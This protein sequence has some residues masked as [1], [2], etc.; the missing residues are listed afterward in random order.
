M[1]SDR[2]TQM[3]VLSPWEIIREEIIEEQDEMFL[4]IFGYRRNEG[5]KMKV[6]KKKQ[7]KK[8]EVN[9]PKRRSSRIADNNVQPSTSSNSDDEPK[10]KTE[11]KLSSH[12]VKVETFKFTS[13]TEISVSSAE[14]FPCKQCDKT[15]NFNNS[16][17][18]HIIAMHHNTWYNCDICNSSFRYNSNLKRHTDKVHTSSTVRYHCNECVQS[19]TYKHNLKAHI[20]KFHAHTT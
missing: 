4:N 18:K 19:F 5:K 20:D 16:L 11:R 2:V 14:N 15:F 8:P 6:E 12:S 13:S 17:K 3:M 7:A 10:E 1:N 9:L